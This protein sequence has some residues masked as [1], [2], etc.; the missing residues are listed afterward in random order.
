M[1]IAWV[2]QKVVWVKWVGWVYKVLA[3]IYNY[4]SGRMYK[5]KL[6]LNLSD[7]CKYSCIL[8][9]KKRIEI[10]VKSSRFVSSID[11]ENS[12]TSYIPMHSFLNHWWET[13]QLSK[14]SIHNLWHQPAFAL[15]IKYLTPTYV[16]FTLPWD[17]YQWNKLCKKQVYTYC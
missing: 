12:L 6:D 3:W 16:L 4:M 15:M 13:D 2:N 1:Q 10:S 9:I 7:F 8:D 5:H 14:R 11:F 17:R